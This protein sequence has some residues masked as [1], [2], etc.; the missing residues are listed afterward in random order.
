MMAGFRSDERNKLVEEA[1]DDAYKRLITPLIQR[2]T[3]YPEL[4]I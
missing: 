4:M 2:Q 3:R 1:V